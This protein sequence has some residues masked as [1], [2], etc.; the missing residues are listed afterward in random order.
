MQ[1]TI[2]YH[3]CIPT[4][5]RLE[6]R[7][8]RERERKVEIL[9]SSR[10]HLSNSFQSSIKP[11][12]PTREMFLRRRSENKF[13]GEINHVVAGPSKHGWNSSNEL[14][15][16]L[17]GSHLL[18][19]SCVWWMSMRETDRQTETFESSFAYVSPYG[20]FLLPDSPHKRIL[21]F[22]A[23]VWDS[24][25]RNPHFHC[26]CSLTYRGLLCRPLH[27]LLFHSRTQACER[28]HQL[29][30]LLQP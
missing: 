13:W 21:E 18:V 25:I 20:G 12:Q 10:R 28:S 23:M 22:Q 19:Q 2:V 5:S 11:W 26:L 3:L 9:N 7:T 1:D 27:G 14:Q 6:S 16:F 24:I 17:W 15:N 4:S 30:Q 8:L 29:V